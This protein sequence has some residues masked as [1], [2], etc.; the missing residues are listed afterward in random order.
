MRGRRR[1]EEGRGEG[2]REGQE[3]EEE[4]EEVEEVGEL[5]TK[6]SMKD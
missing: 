5:V 3:V 2:G 1:K 4:E 6:R